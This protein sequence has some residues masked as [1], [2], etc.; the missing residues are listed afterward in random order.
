MSPLAALPV[1]L[2]DDGNT[3]ADLALVAD[4]RAALPS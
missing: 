4:L 2:F 1:N 3:D